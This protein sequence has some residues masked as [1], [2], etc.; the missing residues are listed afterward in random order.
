MQG[1]KSWAAGHSSEIE[2]APLIHVEERPGSVSYT[3]AIG[4]GPPPAHS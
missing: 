1:G 2:G 4:P 3:A